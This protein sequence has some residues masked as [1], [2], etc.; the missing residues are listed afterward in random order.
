MGVNGID[1][2]GKMDSASRASWNYH[3]NLFPEHL[4]ANDADYDLALAA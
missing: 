2:V 4:T 3:V 1:R